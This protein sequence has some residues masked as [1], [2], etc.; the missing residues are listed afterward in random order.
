M[1]DNFNTLATA[2]RESGD[3]VKEQKHLA[4][5]DRVSKASLA[6]HDEQMQQNALDLEGKRQTGDAALQGQR[7]KAA[8]SEGALDRASRERIAALERK[9]KA[10]AEVLT[11]QE[12]ENYAMMVESGQLGLTAL[13]KRKGYDVMK[14]VVGY[15]RDNKITV[16]PPNSP[17]RAV[18][19][20]LSGSRSIVEELKNLSLGTVGEDGKRTG[21]LHSTGGGFGRVRQGVGL[22]AGALAQQ[23]TTGVDASVY[24]DAKE[25]FLSALAKVTG[26]VGTL[27]DKDMELARK[28]IPGL[29]ASKAKAEQQWAMLEAFIERKISETTR[30][31]ST[32]LTGPRSAEAPEV[33]KGVAK[34]DTT[35]VDLLDYNGKVRTLPAWEVPNAIA[36]G[37]KRAPIK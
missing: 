37:W 3:F 2:A 1:R 34:K 5:L 36:G 12:V 11:P 22:S 29:S 13:P 18:V 25:S 9:A 21:G 32:P 24:M 8:A 28:M 4:A 16:F 6:I 26:Q 23:T 35:P 17:A 10:E 31:Y 15:L 19:A 27:S 7:D 14:A 30:V 20:A 33:A